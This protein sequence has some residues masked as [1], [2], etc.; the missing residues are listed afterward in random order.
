M[1]TQTWCSL[2]RAEQ[3]QTRLLHY[4]FQTEIV[5]FSLVPTFYRE[6]KGGAKSSRVS[7]LANQYFLFVSVLVHRHSNLTDLEDELLKW[8]AAMACL[9]PRD[10]ILICG[11]RNTSTGPRAEQH[12]HTALPP[13]WP[14]L[15]REAQGAEPRLTRHWNCQMLS[16]IQTSLSNTNPE[17]SILLVPCSV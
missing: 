2:T 11:G 9:S 15:L 4:A 17:L 14:A 3:C 16:S 12:F 10:F 1:P 6:G 5:F 7:R 8:T 13:A